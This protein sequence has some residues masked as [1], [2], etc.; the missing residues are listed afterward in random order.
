MLVGS[1]EVQIGE[2]VLEEVAYGWD[3]TEGL[4]ALG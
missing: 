3:G 2:V 4:A 1:Q